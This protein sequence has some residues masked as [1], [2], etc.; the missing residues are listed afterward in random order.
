MNDE[1]WRRAEVESPCVKVC[2]ISPASGLCIG[3]HRTGEEIG[4]WSRM[5][6]TERR[7]IMAVLPDRNPAPAQRRGGRKGRRHGESS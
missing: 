5:T 7:E 4:R 6:P 1:V 2:V 3:C